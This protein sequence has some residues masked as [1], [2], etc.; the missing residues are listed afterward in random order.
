[1]DSSLTFGQQL[2]RSGYIFFFFS[3]FSPLSL[4]DSLALWVRRR[5]H[6][7][8]CFS[9]EGTPF[10]VSDSSPHVQHTPPL[11]S[12]PPPLF[13][14]SVFSDFFSNHLPDC[15]GFFHFSFLAPPV[16]QHTYRVSSNPGR[17]YPQ[18]RTQNHLHPPPAP[19]LASFSPPFP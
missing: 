3:P 10:L 13:L 7:H 8:S 2:F 15:W 1:M 19:L 14:H 4:L 5:S 11:P 18:R 6:F 16:M 17:R 12:P 9:M